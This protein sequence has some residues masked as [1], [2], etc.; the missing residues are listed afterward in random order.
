MRAFF[1]VKVQIENTLSTF[2]VSASPTSDFKQYDLK[3]EDVSPTAKYFT[4]DVS[5]TY[6][7]ATDYFEWNEDEESDNILTSISNEIR[8]QKMKWRQHV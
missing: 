1:S 6:F 2:N 7:T 3:I 5:M 4:E 8:R